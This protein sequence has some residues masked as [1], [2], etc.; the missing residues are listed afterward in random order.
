MDNHK[1]IQVLDTF[2]RK[3][4]REFSKFVES[5]YFNTDKHCI[6]LVE[7]LKREFAKKGGFQLSRTR[8]EKLFS[9]NNASDA[10]LL[11]VK[12]SLLTRLT[13]QFLVQQNLE[14]DNLLADHLL[15][16]NLFDRGL[17]NHFERI[18]R[19][20]TQQK[21]SQS[22]VGSDYYL[23]KFMVEADFFKNNMT[24]DK[25]IFLANENYQEINN[26]LDI[27]YLIN[28]TELHSGMDMFSRVYG[29]TYDFPALPLLDNLFKAANLAK[30][31]IVEI[32]YTAH[33]ITLHP[34]DP[35]HFERLRTL[36]SLHA[37]SITP[38]NLQALY[39]LL[40]NYCVHR[41]RQGDNEYSQKLYQVFREME[42]TG[43]L[44]IDKWFNVRILQNMIISALGV[45]EFEWVE[46]IIDK[47]VDKIAPNIRTCTYNYFQ[48]IYFFYKENYD[49]TIKHLSEVYTVDFEFNMNIKLFLVKAYYEND[50]EYNH[51]TEQVI[52]SFKAFFKQSKTFNSSGKLS[53][54]N[55]GNITNSLYRVKHHEGRENIED[56]V[57]K[58]ENCEFITG[59]KW[60]LEKIKELQS[61]SVR[62]AQ[63]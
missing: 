14:S 39:T 60:L 27:L 11:N 18:Y 50:T 49:A 51:Y 52:R 33:Q 57:R 7:I 15:L 35:R 62:R 30:Y 46:N 1:L 40:A 8:L 32:Y 9:K 48:A 55:F 34:D 12:L 28:K 10:S 23:R 2:D 53:Y 6:R 29:K 36:L 21:L 5:P 19:K 43:I 45:K 63:C 54:I 44:F 13:E 4:W 22:K 37:A 26:T 56:V 41:N 17:H 24:F 3:E 42:H 38:F 20:N 25:K 31:P 61:R 16:D 58:L 47:Y 59:K